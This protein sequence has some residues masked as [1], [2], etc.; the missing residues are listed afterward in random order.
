MSSSL[1]IDRTNLR[2][3]GTNTL[4]SP[5]PRWDALE[6]YNACRDGLTGVGSNANLVKSR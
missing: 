3:S 6:A 2:T 1:A 4:P 5:S